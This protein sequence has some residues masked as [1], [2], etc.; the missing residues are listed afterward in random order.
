MFGKSRKGQGHKKV[1][2]PWISFDYANIEKPKTLNKMSIRKMALEK[3][4]FEQAKLFS[5]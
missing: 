4:T 5:S 1:E 2:N 3:I